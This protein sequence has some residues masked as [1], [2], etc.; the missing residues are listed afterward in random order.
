MG[1]EEEIEIRPSYL[2]TPGG[3]RVA[4]YEFAMSLAKAIKIMYE[5]DL[6]KLEE[7]VNRLEDAAKIFQEFE[8][9]LSNME[10]SLDDLERRLELDLGDISDKL[11]ALID[12]FHE[13]AEK[14]E[15]LEEILARG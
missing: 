11:S 12:A 13:L 5:D 14:V 3:R 9:R 4:T 2:E 10:K 8:S 15:R 1:E 7:R 6:T